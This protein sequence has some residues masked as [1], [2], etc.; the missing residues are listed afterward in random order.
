MK[1]SQLFPKTIKETPSDADNVSTALL[2][3]GGY[4]NRL[5]SGVFTILPLGQKV[6][7]KIENII[8][9]E[10]NSLGGQELFMPALQPKELW[11]RSGRWEKLTG[12][13]YQFADPADR[14]TGLAM[15]HEEVIVDLLGRQSL[16]YNDLPIKLYQFQNKFRFEPR[17]K[18]G[19]LRTREFIMKDL[20]SAH[21]TEAELDEYYPQVRDAYLRIF[22]QVKVPALVT[23]AS[24]GVFTPDFS[25]EFQSICEVGEDTI[26][27]C[28][29]NDYAVNKEVL[30]R[31]GPTCPTH[32]EELVAH[33]AV[34]VGNIFKLGTKFSEDM[35]V[36]Y[37]DSDG[38][39][40]PLWLASYGI[41]LGRL[42][43][44]IVEHHHDEQG[45]IWPSSV[46]P[47]TAH[48]IDLTKTDEEKKQAKAVYEQ[49]IEAGCDV[50]FDDRELSA[51]AKFADAD[52]LGIPIRLVVSSKTLAEQSVEI[53]ERSGKETKLVPISTIAETVGSL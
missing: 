34:E 19:L 36:G 1:Q 26:H 46:A 11:D 32:K 24:G 25:H 21:T 42:M 48:L 39:E 28:P 16:S 14:P 52:L 15:T 30:D 2:M 47:F 43:G 20:Y 40:K 3:R 44:I 37:T 13:M 35:S 6:M 41:G 5:M 27:V 29:Q 53:K 38:T 10:M 7:Q 49:L 8:R 22:K 33:K 51:G 9:L 31:T 50:L 18:S 45:I 17:A 23:L 4:I 12:D